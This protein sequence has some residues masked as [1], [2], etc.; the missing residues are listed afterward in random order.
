MKPE[1]MCSALCPAS[2]TKVFSGGTIDDSSARDGSR[3]EKLKNAFLYRKKLV[4]GCTCNGKNGLGLAR[5]D[6]KTDPTL[7]AG[8]I[9]V[10]TDGLNVYSESRT[11]QR[12]GRRPKITTHFTPIKKSSLVSRS[13]RRTL[14]RI[15]I[16][17][18][19][20]RL[21]SQQEAQQVKPD[22]PDLTD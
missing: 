17:K 4:E 12:R 5:I 21:K 10:M 18:T 19:R 2:P 13:F 20:P 6:L 1:E 15:E 7:E 16:A 3:Y 11:R 9:V 22:E 14:D 8:D